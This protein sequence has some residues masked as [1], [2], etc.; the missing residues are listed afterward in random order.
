MTQEAEGL[1]NS[2]RRGFALV[3]RILVN[4]HDH[5]IIYYICI[6]SILINLMLRLVD[7]GGAADIFA[8]GSIILF[9][10]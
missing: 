2:T 3:Q 1:G 4:N 5:N 7:N 9:S 6:I 10:N 8:L